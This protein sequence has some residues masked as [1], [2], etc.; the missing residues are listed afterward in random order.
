MK[1]I[2]NINFQQA[3]FSAF[4]V[5]AVLRFYQLQNQILSGD[6]W[7][8]IHMAMHSTYLKI[9]SDFGTGAHSIPIALYYRLLIDTVGLSELTMYIPFFVSGILIIV[10]I[11]LL[12]RR[13][14][15]DF[16]AGVLAWLLSLSPFLIF[17]SRFARVYG[18]I[19]FFGFSGVL[20]FY[21]WMLTGKKKHFAL[22][23][24]CAALTSYLHIVAIPF[25]FAPLAYYSISIF[26]RKKEVKKIVLSI[27][28]LKIY[29]AALM[30]TVALL[31][32]PVINSSHI[33]TDRANQTDIAFITIL[34]S[35]PVF[36]GSQNKLVII[37]FLLCL[38]LGLFDG[39]KKYRKLCIYLT[40]L[41]LIQ[42][43][44]VF[45]SKPPA[46]NAVHMFSKYIIVVGPVLLLFISIGLRLVINTLKKSKAFVLP[47]IF[48]AYWY[49]CTPSVFF[50]YNNATN[51]YIYAQLFTGKEFYNYI[52]EHHLVEAESL[53]NLPAFY[54]EMGSYPP[55][56]FTI[57]EA[58]YHYDGLLTFSYQLTHRQKLL[59]GFVNGLCSKSRRGEVPVSFANIDFNHFIAIKN[60]NELVDKNVD[61][62][63]FHKNTGLNVSK[64]IETYQHWFGDPYFEDRDIIVFSIKVGLKDRSANLG[65]FS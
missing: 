44:F 28:L 3:V 43:I 23:V 51:F 65:D 20:F 10:V 59:M 54:K 42:T 31:I 8:S 58:P 22:Y 15:G 27:K 21:Y 52:F 48:A 61:F 12:L 49:H 35:F 9:L 34:K 19:V 25:V 6:E 47:V 17:Y 29:F 55:G 39:F 62:V 50:Q 38:A 30:P 53:E 18:L 60:K 46:G 2:K 11:P 13:L 26:Y 63:I 14:V 57:V 4:I 40:F 41:Y 56:T 36:F 7:H 1:S 16:N 33:I 45:L 64:C 37:I 24:F 5:G 32:V